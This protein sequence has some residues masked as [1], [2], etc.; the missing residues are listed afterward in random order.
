[1]RKLVDRPQQGPWLADLI[2]QWEVA[3]KL[4]ESPP[5]TLISTTWAPWWEFELIRRVPNVLCVPFLE[6]TGLGWPLLNVALWFSP[7][8]SRRPSQDGYGPT[9]ET[10]RK[11]GAPRLRDAGLRNELVVPV[12]Q[13]ATRG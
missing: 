6:S 7:R 5:S 9:G 11:T 13:L 10:S 8:L 12:E 3:R 2:V 1:M 4:S